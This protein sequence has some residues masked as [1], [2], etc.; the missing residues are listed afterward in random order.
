MLIE[1]V[2]RMRNERL[3]KL[4]NWQQDGR[5]RRRRPKKEMKRLLSG[6]IEE[7]RPQK[8]VEN[9]ERRE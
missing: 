9:K 4:M 8:K 7:V 2:K 1:C 3:P 6:R 5:N